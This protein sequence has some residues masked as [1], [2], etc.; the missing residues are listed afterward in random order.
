[1]TMMVAVDFA[2]RLNKGKDKILK[3]KVSDF[4]EMEAR[5]K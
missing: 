5:E 2:R 3:L 1:M 4:V